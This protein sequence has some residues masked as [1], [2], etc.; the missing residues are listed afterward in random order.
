MDLNKL[1]KIVLIVCLLSIGISVFYYFIV[2]L[3]QKEKV[4]LK[5]QEQEQL[6]KEQEKDLEQQEKC[7]EIGTKAYNDYKKNNSGVDYFFGPEF[8]F[9][10]K[11]QKCFY[12]GGYS[13]KNYWERFVK[14]AYTDESII[15]TF[16]FT[17]REVDE[18]KQKSIE[19]FWDKYA[20][21]FEQ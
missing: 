11:L 1:L 17:D 2:F 8:H 21:L 18:L 7:R 19:A 10:K 4:K 6:V 12:S 14:N 9:N 13:H 16:N 5:Q 15:I 3:P 20:V